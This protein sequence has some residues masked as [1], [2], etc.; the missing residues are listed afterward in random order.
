M[1]HNEHRTLTFAIAI[2]LAAALCARAAS[3]ADDGVPAEPS[4]APA[5]ASA[6]PAAE[7]AAEPAADGPPVFLA[8]TG[9]K[10]DDVLHLRDVPSADSKSL[11]DI[12]PN[13]RGL[14][15]VGCMRIQLSMDRYMYLSKQERNDA[16][17]PWCRIEYQGK[18]GW[19]SARYVKEEG[20]AKR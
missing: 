20:A 13:A 10:S 7:G 3:A 14:K 1:A 6:A 16:Q 5:A 2:A 15:K 9:V 17:A 18:Q 12:P 11:A 19:V 4:A 8:V